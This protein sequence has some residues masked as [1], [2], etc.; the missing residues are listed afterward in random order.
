M[1]SEHTSV[2][3][4]YIEEKEWLLHGMYPIQPSL[5]LFLQHTVLE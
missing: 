3:V 1:P 5:K 4:D 2:V